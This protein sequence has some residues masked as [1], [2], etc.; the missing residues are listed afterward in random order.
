MNFDFDFSNVNSDNFMEAI[1]RLHELWVAEKAE[2]DEQVKQ[3]QK[4]IE[5][6]AVLMEQLQ[7]TIDERQLLLSENQ[8]LKL[9]ANVISGS[10]GSKQLACPPD[11]IEPTAKKT[12]FRFNTRDA[13]SLTSGRRVVGGN[14]VNTQFSPILSSLPSQSLNASGGNSSSST[15]TLVPDSV[16]SDAVPSQLNVECSVDSA[17]VNSAQQL[18]NGNVNDTPWSSVKSKFQRKND[19]QNRADRVTPIQL[20]NIESARLRTVGADIA[21]LAGRDEIYIQ[22][23]SDGKQPRIHC[24]TEAAKA[25][26]FNYLRTND[27]QFNSYNNASTR[28][29]SF[30]VRGMLGETD[31][32]AIQMI[33]AAV[34]DV[35][36]RAEFDV[37]RFIT[38]YQKHH[39]NANRSPLFRITVPASVLDQQLLDIRTIGYCG[40]KIEKMKKSSV[41]QCRNC[42]RLHHTTNQCN[43]KFRCVQCASDHLWGNCP[44]AVNQAMPIACINCLD[45]N[46]THTG[47]TANDL[48]NCNFYKKLIESQRQR[49]NHQQPSIAV[50]NGLGS[51][52]GSGR[53]PVNF[54]SVKPISTTGISP[55][56]GV[57]RSTYAQVTRSGTGFASSGINEEQLTTLVAATVRSILS[58]LSNGI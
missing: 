47:H 33:A 52:V 24:N 17:R 4:W 19:R 37:N 46:L 5:E 51:A 39:A 27:L 6:R 34:R 29:K 41:V 35:G 25:I 13:S 8:Q 12:K 48:L 43:Y 45:A 23:L 42:Q 31:D 53:A 7:R 28:R 1:Q 50:R 11:S 32:E 54:V 30:I 18:E 26:A 36:V 9:N 20:Q 3:H 21:K 15:S 58:A 55:S 2:K 16:M 14:S 22:R 44:R 10:G 40:V 38:P 49:L 56:S 57:S